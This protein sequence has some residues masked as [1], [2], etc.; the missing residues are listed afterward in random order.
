MLIISLK[1][2]KYAMKGS[3]IPPKILSNFWEDGRGG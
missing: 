3:L 1:R 2:K